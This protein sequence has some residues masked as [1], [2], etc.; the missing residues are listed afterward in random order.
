MAECCQAGT[1]LPARHDGDEIALIG[2]ANAGKTT[3]FNQLT[4]A[5]QKTGNWPGVT[6]ERRSGPMKLGEQTL[7]LVDLPGIY[8]MDHEHSPDEA[9]ARQYL[10]QHRP[11]LILN[12]VDAS[13]LERNLYLT[14]QLLE[15]GLPLVVVLN[16]TDVAEQQG[17][18][19]DPAALS[20][21]LGVPV[22]PVVAR[23]GQGLD[24]LRKQALAAL[25]AAAPTC[26]APYPQDLL[27]TLPT[28]RPLAQALQ[29]KLQALPATERETLQDQ[30]AD[31]R[32]EMAH[33]AA[34]AAQQR[35]EGRDRQ[36]TARLDRIALHP[37]LGVPVFLLMMYL[38][39]FFSIRLSNAFV[40]FFDLAAGA[41]FID[42]PDHWL[43]AVGAP[44]WIRIFLAQGLGAGLQTVATFI[45]VIGLLY[46]FLSILEDSGYMAR[47][48]FVVNRLMTWLGLSGKAFVPL[49][50]G[51]G[52]NVPAIMATRTL[53]QER[54]RLATIMMAPFISCGAR[55]SV[56]ALFVSI[57]F[58]EQGANIVFLL[59]VIGVLAAIGTGLL[60]KHTLLK[61]EAEPLLMEL[62]HYHLPSFKSLL[63][64]S[65]IRLKGF[66]IGAGKVIILMVMLIQVLDNIGTDGSMGENRQGDSLLNATAKAITPAFAP[67]GIE[68][69]N[70]PATVGI[71]TGLLAKEVVAGTLTALYREMQGH[72]EEDTGEFSLPAALGEAAATI[73][74]NLKDA[75]LNWDDPLE[76]NQIADLEQDEASQSVAGVLRAKFHGN[77]G[78]FAYL[79]FVLLYFPCASA[80]AA[81]FRE[82]GP[83]WT[84]FAVL[85]TTSLAWMS[86]S[87]FYQLA[88][89]SR[90]PMISLAWL[91]GWLAFLLGVW[92]ILRQLS[93]PLQA[94]PHAT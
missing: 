7:T 1:D 84:A 80:T 19:I 49:I 93:K 23:T 34:L 73:P 36:L 4:G 32:F 61:G 58:R 15:F 53:K 46:F 6:V 59:Y 77:T 24:A 43:Q 94:Q 69:D 22:V 35:H 29:D 26:R 42:A 14:S 71:L 28:D 47:A 65:W 18:H 57:F 68:E 2:N 51:L 66:L 5:R 16:M 21:A 11:A 72:T 12:V 85:W 81:I 20:D 56:Y 50:V 48:A 60:L 9:V 13:N 78:V 70:W 17:K 45:P 76:M 55:L 91:A 30:L 41:L 40:D 38:L 88:Q 39:F 27:Q 92:A 10:L 62:P 82:S 74:A 67:M 75:F 8:T 87:T 25:G 64:T 89:F 86:A 90:Q 63:V 79:L 54:E 33:Q 44:D 83:R 37:W 31:A 52:C 3:L